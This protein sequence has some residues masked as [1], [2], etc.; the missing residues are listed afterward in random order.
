MCGACALCSSF[1]S[2]CSWMKYYLV[3]SPGDAWLG[4]LAVPLA[5]M[6]GHARCIRQHLRSL[7]CLYCEAVSICAGSACFTW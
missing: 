4:C 5:I 7:C 2:D 1:H 6:C 3:G